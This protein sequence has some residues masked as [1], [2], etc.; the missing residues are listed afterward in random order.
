MKKIAYLAEEYYV[1]VAIH[2]ISSP[3]GTMLTP[4]WQPL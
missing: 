4:T 1:P 3:I 2:N